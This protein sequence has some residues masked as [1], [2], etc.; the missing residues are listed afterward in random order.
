[1]VI[2]GAVAFCRWDKYFRYE[3]INE[4]DTFRALEDTGFMLR[5]EGGRG[6]YGDVS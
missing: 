1:M 5:G 3:Y 2:D 4:K 6:I